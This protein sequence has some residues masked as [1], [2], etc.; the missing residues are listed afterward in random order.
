MPTRTSV[1]QNTSMTLPAEIRIQA[2]CLGNADLSE[3]I[4]QLTV[5]SGTKNPFHIYFPKTNSNGLAVLSA[6]DF[7]GQFSDHFEMGLMDYNGAIETAHERTTLAL[8]DPAKMAQNRASLA[9]WPLLRHE[10]SQWPSREA[11]LEYLLSTRNDLFV[12]SPQK[13]ELPTDGPISV[14]IEHRCG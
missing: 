14:T 12:L 9:V 3:L 4:F 13:I 11:R 10:R 6:D 1:A 5:H 8:F 2:G 7:R